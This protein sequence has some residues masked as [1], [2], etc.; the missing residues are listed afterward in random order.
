MD[1]EEED[2]DD[3]TNLPEARDDFTV[4]SKIRGKLLL[5]SIYLLDLI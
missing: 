4:P 1:E 3:I 5:I 2:D